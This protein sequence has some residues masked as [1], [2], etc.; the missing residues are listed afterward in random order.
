MEKPPE[1]G[2]VFSFYVDVMDVWLSAYVVAGHNPL[3]SRF[4]LIS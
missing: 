2:A 3:Q 1:A 4:N